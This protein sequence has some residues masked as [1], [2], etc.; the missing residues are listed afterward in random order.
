MTEIGL[1]DV[2]T[3]LEQYVNQAEPC[4]CPVSRV[5]SSVVDLILLTVL[6]ASAR[7]MRTVNLWTGG[8]RAHHVL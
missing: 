8:Y 4:P 5:G 1:G 7:D 3:E 2:A 6:A